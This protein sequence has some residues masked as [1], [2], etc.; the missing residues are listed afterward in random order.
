M[1]WMTTLLEF[2]GSSAP[3]ILSV[4]FL[5]NHLDFFPPLTPSFFSDNA[6]G[7]SVQTIPHAMENYLHNLAVR[8]TKP[9]RIRVGGNSM[10]M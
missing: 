2:H 1:L 7:K 5:I 3:L 8:M 9:L 4:S 10:D 6:G